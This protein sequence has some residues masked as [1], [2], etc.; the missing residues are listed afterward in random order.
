MKRIFIL[1]IIL[2]FGALNVAFA[3][4]L[5]VRTNAL[6]WATLSPNVGFELKMSPKITLSADGSFC[7]FGF[8]GFNANHSK[9]SLDGRYWLERP[10]LGHSVGVGVAAASY[11]INLFGFEQ[12][13]NA[14]SLGVRYGYT[15]IINAH[16]NIEGIVG[17][18]VGA[19]NEPLVYSGG[20]VGQDNKIGVVVDKIAI[21]FVYII[22]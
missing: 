5:A 19:I 17:V 21:S 3:E 8:D 9:I 4:R 15:H 12:N 6:G 7:P 14:Y 1:S 2:C 20:A 11:D 18:G 22:R 13:G 10:F 16:W